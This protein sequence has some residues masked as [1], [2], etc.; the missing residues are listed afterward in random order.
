MARRQGDRALADGGEKRLDVERGAGAMGEAEPLQA[1]HRQQRRVDRAALGLA[2]PRLDV[3][4][5]QLDPQVGTQP[6]RLRL[7]AQ[8]GRAEPRA[9]GR[10]AIESARAEIERVA[11]VLA[12]QEAG[13]RHAVGQGGR[14]VLGRM[15]GEVDAAVEQG[16]IDFLG[17]QT[18]AAGFGERP[19]LDQVAAGADDGDRDAR[20]VPAVSGGETAAGLVRLGQ[21]E[22]RAAR[23]EGEEDCGG[24]GEAPL[25]EIGA[26]G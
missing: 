1:G 22:R 14:Q 7:A 17:E 5:Q 12:R 26:A 13:H 3:A 6:E 24:H 21:G 19:V 23:A 20:L 2:E 18:L 11:R 8:R 25:R 15:D 16:G 10:P 4:A 9:G